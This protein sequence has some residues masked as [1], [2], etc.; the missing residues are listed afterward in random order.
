M[1]YTPLKI[2]LVKSHDEQLR[3]FYRHFKD[4]LDSAHAVVGLLTIILAYAF[5][6]DLYSGFLFLVS[7]LQVLLNSL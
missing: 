6:T 4:E 3:D 1:S 5:R 7:S 2:M